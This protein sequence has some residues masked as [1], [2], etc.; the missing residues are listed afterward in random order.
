MAERAPRITYGLDRQSFDAA[1]LLDGNPATA[2]IVPL[3]GTSLTQYL[4]IEFPEPYT[5]QSLTV[6]LD[7]WNTELPSALEV[8]VDGRKYE[9]VRKFSTRWPVSSVNFPQ[10]T[11]RY[12]RIQFNIPDPGGDWVFHRF[13]K[14]IP[15]SAGGTSTGAAHRRYFRKSGFYAPGGF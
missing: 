7:V 14:G 6:A 12:F 1:N 13:A 11:A 15:L 8:S 2:A 3:A 5:A 9:T 10:V 4:N